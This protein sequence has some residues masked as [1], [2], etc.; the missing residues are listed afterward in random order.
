M[1]KVVIVL[2][3]I[4]AIAVGAYLLLPHNIQKRIVYNLPMAIKQDTII[5][6]PFNGISQVLVVNV[7]RK[8][9]Q[10]YAYVKL[11]E[12]IPLPTAAYYAPRDRYR[13]DTIIAWLAKRAKGNSIVIGLTQRD[14]S[15]SNDAIK[16]WG[17]MGLGYSPGK[18]C[19]VSTFRLHKNNLSEQLYKVAIHELG[20]TFGLPHCASKSCF[21]AAA[22]GKNHL[23]AESVFCTSCMNIMKCSGWH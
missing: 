2:S 21:M 15:T 8:V 17:V 23:D 14:I 6:Q 11:N 9:S 4:F 13:A 7:Y 12:A 10:N 16:D 5:I 22:E 1:K 3:L 20:H 18:A 19:V